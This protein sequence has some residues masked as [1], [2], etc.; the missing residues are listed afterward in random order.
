MSGAG[1]FAG[2]TSPANTAKCFA[3]SSPTAWV[4]DGADGGFRGGGGHREGPAG[5]VRFLDDPGDAGPGGHDAGFDEF[6]VDGG[7]ALVPGQDGLVHGGLVGEAQVRA[8]VR[9]EDAAHPFLAAA[10]FDLL[11][12]FFNAPLHG[13]VEV[14]EGL[15][16]GGQ[17]AVLFGVGEDAVAVEDEGGHQRPPLPALPNCSVRSLTMVMISARVC[18]NSD[19]GSHLLFCSAC[20][21]KAR[22]DCM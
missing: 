1:F 5:V 16:E 21:R 7:L 2:T 15:V 22:E 14:G 10:D 17:V 3:R 8:D 18:L 4:E 11:R 6:L 19:G 12:V 13:D 20:L 9:G